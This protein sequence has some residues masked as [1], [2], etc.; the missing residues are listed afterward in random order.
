MPAY[1]DRGYCIKAP[2]GQGAYGITYSV[3][4]GDQV[5]AMKELDI[6]QVTASPLPYHIY[7][8]LTDDIRY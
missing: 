6:V 8:L 1:I 2:F 3:A 7:F 5:F 4:K